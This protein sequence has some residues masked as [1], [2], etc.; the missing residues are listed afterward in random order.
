MRPLLTLAAMM[1]AVLFALPPTASADDGDKAGAEALKKMKIYYVDGGTFDLSQYRGKVVLVNFWAHWCAPCISEFPS[2][3]KM[4]SEIGMDKF[5]V[6]IISSIKDLDK[7]K[8]AIRQRGIPFKAAYYNN[9]ETRI[10]VL[11]DAIAG[12]VQGNQIYNT[13]PVTYLFDKKGAVVTR[14][15]GPFDYANPKLVNA[16]KGLANE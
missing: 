3:A 11:K 14:F 7:D 15:V 13:L 1:V 10:E 4:Q 6:V 5:E 9:G 8:T 2:M 12:R 16:V